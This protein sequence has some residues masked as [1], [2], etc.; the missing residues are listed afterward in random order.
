MTVVLFPSVLH[1]RY[2][3]NMRNTMKSPVL[4]VSVVV[5]ICAIIAACSSSS[6]T[7]R[8]IPE[9]LLQEGDIVFRRGSGV[10]S[11]AVLHA[12]NKKGAYSHIGIVV[13]RG[14]SWNVIHAVPGEPDYEGDPARVKMESIRTFF[15]PERAV[16]GAIMRLDSV[17]TGTAVR[18]AFDLY[19]VRTPFDHHYD[20]SDTTEMYCTELVCFSYL[21]AGV[22]LAEGRSSRVRIPGFID[23]ACV[24]PSD[25]LACGKLKT[26]YQF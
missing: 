14:G 23:V 10:M 4:Y 7:K 11:H 1:L 17:D 12:G 21:K 5:W 26:V 20:S 25:V 8:C 15:A 18:C 6:D 24:L 2:D 9:N 19:R 16:S 22:D 13:R 3:G